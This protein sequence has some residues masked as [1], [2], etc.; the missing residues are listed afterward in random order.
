[1]DLTAGFSFIDKI[2]GE[3]NLNILQE[4][5]CSILSEIFDSLTAFN[6]YFRFTFV[7]QTNFRADKRTR[8]PE[9]VIVKTV[10]IPALAD[11]TF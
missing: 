6:I 2:C 10:N 11:L 3:W 7:S 5:V 4:A 1:M 9:Y 8:P